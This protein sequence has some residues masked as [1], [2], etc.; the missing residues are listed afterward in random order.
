MQLI[1]YEE[2]IKDNNLTNDERI[3]YYTGWV[4]RFLKLNLSDRLTNNDKLKQFCAYL[5][6]DEEIEDWQRHQ[7]MH[8][9][10]IY[11]NMY[12]AN[13]KGNPG[14]EVHPDVLVVSEK[15]RTV[16]RLKHYAYRTEQ[17]YL[18]WVRKYFTYCWTKRHDCKSSATVKLYLSYLATRRKV[19]AST[20][21]QAFNS[22][23]FLF[24]NVFEIT[25]DDIS[26]AVRAKSKKNL[27]VVLGVDEVKLLFRQ[28][29]GTRRM[30]LELIYG[31]GL[32]V[33]E[34]TR[35]RVMNLDFA[36]G[37]LIVRDGKGGKDRAVKL[38]KKLIVQLEEHLV[39]TKELHDQDLAI[40]HG[41][42]Y[43]PPALARKYPNAGREWKWQYVFPSV[44]LAVDPRSGKVRRHHILDKTVQTIMRKAV[45]DAKI[46]KKATVHSLRHSF[47]THLL[48]SGVNIREIQELLGHKNVETTMIYTH[49]VKDIT[50]TPESPL[51]ML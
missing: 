1:D 44:N 40:G 45:N 9:V 11:L 20:Q 21:N 27:P 48:M 39:K 18:D 6:A 34:L 31:T 37:M 43:L 3:S 5:D 17:T 24:R 35:L 51:D 22:L 36:S 4:R 41:E 50:R 47:A 26:G 32:R 30:I 13:V 16:L 23:L 15:M 25:L 7:G 14:T 29:S 46:P 10:E 19:A 28:V 2:Y 12:L 33:S 8:A 42:V 49:V 38:P